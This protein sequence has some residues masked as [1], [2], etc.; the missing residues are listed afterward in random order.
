MCAVA[1]LAGIGFTVSLLIGDLAF[2]TGSG[3]DQVKA[4]VLVGSVVS[5]PCSPRSC[6]GCAPA[7]PE[8]R[9]TADGMDSGRLSRRAPPTGDSQEDRR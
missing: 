8:R 3:L 6:C 5:A 7:L 9:W 1:V 4:A 2:A